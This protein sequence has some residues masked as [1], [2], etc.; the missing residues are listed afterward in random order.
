[1]RRTARE[2]SGVDLTIRLMLLA[3]SPLQTARH[4]D[5]LPLDNCVSD[6]AHYRT[7]EY[8][9]VSRGEGL[10]KFVIWGRIVKPIQDGRWLEAVRIQRLWKSPLS[11]RA[12]QTSKQ[13]G[14]ATAIA[15]NS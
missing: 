10:L 7:H 14:Q 13:M 6:A 9:G 12:E 3:P 1:M 11:P 15:L 2:E 8:V 4:R 5:A